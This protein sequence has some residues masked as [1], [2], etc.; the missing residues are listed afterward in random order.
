MKTFLETIRAIVTFLLVQTGLFQ[1]SNVANDELIPRALLFSNPERSEAKLSPDGLYIA[2]LAPNDR[3][4][5]NIWMQQTNATVEPIQLTFDNGRGILDYHWTYKPN[6]LVFSQDNDG[7]ENFML[8]KLDVSDKQKLQPEAISAQPGV[9]A[10]VLA[11]SNQQMNKLIIGA[12]DENPTYHSIYEFDLTTNQKQRIFTNSRFDVEDM[13]FDNDLNLRV[14]GQATDDGGKAYYRPS[15][16]ANRRSLTSSTSDWT[17]YTTV[18]AEDYEITKPILFSLDNNQIYWIWGPGSDLGRLAVHPFGRPNENRYIYSP[19]KTE[20]SLSTMFIHPRDKTVLAVLEAYHKQEIKIL[21]DTVRADFDYLQGMKTD[22]IPLIS[23][24]SEDFMTWLVVYNS[25]QYPLE[26]WLY[27]RRQRTLRF[28]FS[29][30]PQLKGKSVAR[31]HGVT[32]TARD[33]LLIPCYLS[34]PPTVRVIIRFI[35]SVVFVSQPS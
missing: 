6:V 16:S 9:Q 21:N 10:V 13:L 18:A 28:L 14:A 23:D 30:Q 34:I 8:F 15:D 33:G 3:G 12:N 4:V 5:Q 29:K 17:L 1:L 32:V 27:D 22:G 2:F 7:D 11:F 25:D 20:I 19:Q 35:V 24:T 26:Y 31:M